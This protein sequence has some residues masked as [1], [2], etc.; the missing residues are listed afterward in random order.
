[1]HSIYLILMVTGLLIAVVFA[2]LVFATGKGDAMGAG[3]GVRTTFQGKPSF[4][5]KISKITL[6]LGISFIVMMLVLDFVS[7]MVYRTANR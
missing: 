3:A 7:N 6:R 5:D 1:M 4:D 2:F